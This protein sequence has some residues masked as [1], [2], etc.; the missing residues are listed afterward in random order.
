MVESGRGVEKLIVKFS[1]ENS[2][3]GEEENGFEKDHYV[4]YVRVRITG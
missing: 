1:D 4:S 2:D 3:K